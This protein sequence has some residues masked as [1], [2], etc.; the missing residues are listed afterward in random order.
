MMQE[1]VDKWECFG[2]IVTV[3]VLITQGLLQFLI[4]GDQQDNWIISVFC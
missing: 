3:L 1:E 2:R 4:E